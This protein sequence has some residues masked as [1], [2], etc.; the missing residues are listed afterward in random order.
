MLCKVY[1]AG[2]PD[3]E[4]LRNTVALLD[5]AIEGKIASDAGSRNALNKLHTALSKEMVKLGQSQENLDHITEHAAEDAALTVDGQ[6]MDESDL[7]NG[8]DIKVENEIGRGNG[9]AQS[10]MALYSSGN[11]NS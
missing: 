3:A 5:E 8:D 11:C 7:L 6:D 1:I 10:Q 2:K 4:N 9:A